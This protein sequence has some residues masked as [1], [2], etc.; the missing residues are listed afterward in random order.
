MITCLVGPADREEAPD[1]VPVR[2]R[3]RHVHRGSQ[4]GDRQTSVLG[5]DRWHVAWWDEMTGWG[6]GGMMGVIESV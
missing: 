6:G 3:N 2:G 1:L 4:R 5:D